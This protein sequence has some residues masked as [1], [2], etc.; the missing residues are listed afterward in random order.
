MDACQTLFAKIPARLV[1]F[2]LAMGA[3]ALA[4]NIDAMESVSHSNYA[5]VVSTPLFDKT[6]SLPIPGQQLHIV[7][8][9]DERQISAD[10]SR[11]LG[12]TSMGPFQERAWLWSD[13]PVDQEIKRIFDLWFPDSESNKA[14]PVRIELAS[15]ET[16]TVPTTNPAAAKATVRLRVISAQNNWHGYQVEASLVREGPNKPENQTALLRACLRKAIREAMTLDWQ[17]AMPLAKVGE[18]GPEPDPWTDPLRMSGS[19]IQSVSRTLVHLGQTVGQSGYGTSLRAVFYHEPETG[20]NPEFW[21]GI[22][23]RD[24]DEPGYTAWVAEVMGGKAYQT[25]LGSTSVVSVSTFGMLF[26][27]EKFQQDGHAPDSWKY[28][29]FDMRQ[30]GRWEPEGFAGLSAEVGAQGAIRVPSTLQFF[31]LGF[32]MEVGQ[33]F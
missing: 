33:R 26:G 32:Y 20:V 19:R 14:I 1:R 16:W 3:A 11:M 29:G 13:E 8:V 12:S 6:D 21:A 23:L 27:I 15:F 31:D 17:H 2:A 24:P 5:Q 18:R 10:N 28:I 7:S 25:R 22:R 9:S 30:G 4:P